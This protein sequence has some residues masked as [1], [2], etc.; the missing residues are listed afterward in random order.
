MKTC[1]HES[2]ASF[3]KNTIGFIK[4]QYSILI[5]SYFFC[6]LQLYSVTM[7]PLEDPCNLSK[8]TFY[9]K[10]YHVTE[11]HILRQTLHPYNQRYLGEFTFTY[12]IYFA[13]RVYYAPNIMRLLIF[14]DKKPHSKFKIMLFH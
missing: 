5:L 7:W 4:N 6:F 13:F 10:F 2:S 14:C 3:L 1:L 12:N 11:I 8:S 9:E